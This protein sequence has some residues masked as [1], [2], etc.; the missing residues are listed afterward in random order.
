VF[1]Y[2]PAIWQAIIFYLSLEGIIFY[3]NYFWLVFFVF[4]IFSL[5][6]FRIFS[7]TWTGWFVGLTFYCS[8]WVILH[9]I[10]YDM[11]RHIFAAIAGLVDY[12]LLFGVYRIIK[13]PDSMTAKSIINMSIM[14]TVFLFFSATYGIYLNFDLPSW[15]LMIFYFSFITLI[16]Q[17]Y[18]LLINKDEN[19]HKVW[20]YSLILGF[21]VLEMGWVIN[22]WPFGYLTTGIILLMFYYIIW[23][24]SQNYFQDILSVK[25]VLSNLAIFILISAIVL[26][27]SRWLPNI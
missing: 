1:L 20:V 15:L 12:F 5:V 24:L 25:K 7:K 27:S 19:K 23:D 2:L 18:F 14:S 3:Q 9:L 21:S 4:I 16:S 10:D 22:F 13:K 17:Q 26:F 6:L 8:V 11:E